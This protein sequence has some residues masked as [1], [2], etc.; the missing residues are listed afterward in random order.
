MKKIVVLVTG[1]LVINSSCIMAMEQKR[2]G[3]IAEYIQGILSNCADQRRRTETP[4]MILEREKNELATYFFALGKSFSSVTGMMALS[5]LQKSNTANC[6]ETVCFDATMINF[7]WV[8]V[9]A[10]ALASSYE[11]YNRKPLFA[12]PKKTALLS[13]TNFIASA[14]PWGCYSMVNDCPNFSPKCIEM[15][16]LLCGLNVLAASAVVVNHILNK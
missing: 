6:K 2:K 1:L 7:L 5:G 10:T 15:R 9:A 11:M 3:F 8:M 4:S 16:Q 14:V 13:G 12:S